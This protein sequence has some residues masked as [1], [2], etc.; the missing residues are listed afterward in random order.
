MSYQ[1]M[2]DLNIVELFKP[3]LSLIS[4]TNAF[5]RR[6]DEVTRSL[7]VAQYSLVFITT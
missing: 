5:N 6:K 4:L 1:L 2:V 3:Y 7:A